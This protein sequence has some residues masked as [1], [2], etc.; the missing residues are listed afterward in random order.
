MRRRN[1]AYMAPQVL[2]DVNHSK[3]YSRH[4]YL[5]ILLLTRTLSYGYHDGTRSPRFE[6]QVD[7]CLTVP[8]EETFGPVVGIQK[9]LWLFDMDIFDSYKR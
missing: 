7:D 5:R 6:C 4:L 2:V 3:C 8:Q 9:V 1:A